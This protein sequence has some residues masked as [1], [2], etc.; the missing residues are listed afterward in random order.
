M[1]IKLNHVLKRNKLTFSKFLEINN[2]SNYTDLQKYCESRKIHCPDLEYYNNFVSKK[3]NYK[4]EKQ[5]KTRTAN[6]PK[7]VASKRRRTRK[8][9]KK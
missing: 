4:D 7:K 2:I 1:S 9:Q 5:E 6:G 3:D 8:T